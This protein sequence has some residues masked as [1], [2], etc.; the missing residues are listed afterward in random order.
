MLSIEDYYFQ[1][2]SMGLRL[3]EGIN[4]K[5]KRNLNAYKFFKSKL[6]NVYIKN[7]KLSTY[8]INF[9]NSILEK[10]L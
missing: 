6:T 1:V 10:M 2:L 9:L 7:E 3:C 5:N 4:L 8:N